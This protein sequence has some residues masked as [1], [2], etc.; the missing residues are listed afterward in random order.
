MDVDQDEWLDPGFLDG[1]VPTSVKLTI[2][3]AEKKA[4]D[5]RIGG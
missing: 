4:Q 1:L 3:E 2:G 5:L